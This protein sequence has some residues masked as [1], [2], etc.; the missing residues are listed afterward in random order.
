DVLEII[1]PFDT[2]GRYNFAFYRNHDNKAVKF[3]KCSNRLTKGSYKD[4]Y[5]YPDIVNCVFYIYSNQF[6][7]YAVTYERGVNKTITYRANNGSSVQKVVEVDGDNAV[8]ASNTFSRSG[9]N[10]SGWNTMSDGSGDPYNVGASVTGLSSNL[11]LYAQ[12]TKKSSGGGGGGGGT[13]SYTPVITKPEHGS[14]SVNPSS[15][16]AGYS[17][18][19]TVTPEE[20]YE[21]EDVIVKDKKGNSLTVT[22]NEDGSYVFTQPYTGRVTIEALLK[23]IE[24]VT[25]SFD[26][27]GVSAAVPEGQRIKKGEKAVKPEDPTAEGYNFTG[28]Y[29]DKGCKNTYDFDTAVNEDLILYAGFENKEKPEPE[30]E[31]EP[32]PDPEDE[33]FGVYFAKVYDDPYEG[34]CYNSEKERYEIAY[35]SYAIKPLIKVTSKADGVL[36]EGIDYRVSYSNNRKVSSK[37]PATI[38]VSGKGRYKSS[39]ILEL[40]ILPADLEEASNHGLITGISDIKVE[41]GK[42]LNP[43]I[44]YRGYKLKSSDRDLSNKAVITKDT[45]I[46]ISGK[47]NFTGTLK[48]I[49]VKVITK[50]DIK[51]NAIKAALKAGK[52]VY[53]GEAQEL[54]ISTAEEAGEL[55]V[56]AGNS[57]TAL[58][59]DTDFI[60]SYSDNTA[61]GKATL[62]VTGIGAYNGTVV[63]KFTIE[64][65]KTADISAALTSPEEPVYH[66]V[67]GAMPDVTVIE[68]K[69]VEGEEGRSEETLN[70]GE[71]YKV[72]YS[73]NKKVGK[74]SFTVK[75]LGNYKGHKDIKG[76]FDI[77]EAPIATA[78]VE[79]AQ[80]IY[81]KP[82]KYLSKPFV[83]LDG[84]QLKTSEYSFKFYEGEVEDVT[85][86]GVKE[87]TSKDKLTLADDEDSKTITIAVTAKGNYTGTA[88]GTY[89]VVRNKSEAIDLSKAKI[90]AKEKNKRYKDVRVS[91][92]EYTGYAIEPEIRV[93]VKI[94]RVWTDLDPELYG[95]SYINNV[96]KGRAVIL[97]N[98]N[99]SETI[100]SKKANFTIS[101]MRMSLFEV[102]SEIF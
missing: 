73:S 23:S 69:T 63:K 26:L 28:W 50:E 12:W 89:E 68:S 91:S 8:I 13:S 75:F 18:T 2:N 76:S 94:N 92:Q 25:V 61:A 71:D 62:T 60:V 64:G 6:S 1:Y 74:G 80:M 35:T 48:D 102:I 37:K 100:G 59:E 19:V 3:T 4:G 39:K 93:M 17:V 65:N 47:G 38:K 11:T 22:K 79:A 88:L 43:L 101:N 54:S 15:P 20:G 70:E 52:H 85:A 5:F 72:S 29:S 40:Y 24:Y 34:V 27:S 7:T 87:L 44:V 45:S 90:V 58:I 41:S 56:T 77:V 83:S 84:V 51:K 86:D 36:K 95:I 82:G 98:G 30:P 21:V 55:T 9:Y 67:R 96:N 81:K 16:K 31:P 14:I 33:S 46:D 97:I 32:E 57:K 10:F 66:N 53:N 42:K 99:G 49:K 78:R